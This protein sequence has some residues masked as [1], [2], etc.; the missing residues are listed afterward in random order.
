MHRVVRRIKN[1]DLVQS[2]GERK[3][4]G[5]HDFC[6]DHSCQICD[7]VFKYFI[8]DLR[9]LSEF[10]WWGNYF[11]F[12]WLSVVGTYNYTKFSVLL[13][14]RE[15][16]CWIILTYLNSQPLGTE[17][18]SQPKGSASCLEPGQLFIKHHN[19]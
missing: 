9:L 5:E 6:V 13:W 15:P 14:K 10:C 3:V 11:Y 12:S 7:Q 17:P 4:P 2:G 8:H 16:I 1:T 18:G 19:V